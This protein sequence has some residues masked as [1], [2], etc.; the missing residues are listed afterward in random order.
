MFETEGKRLWALKLCKRRMTNETETKQQRFMNTILLHDVSKPTLFRATRFHTPRPSYFL[1]FLI[2]M[3]KR[4][5][6]KEVKNN[7]GF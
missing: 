7:G 2:D 1:R 5:A 6:E 3:Q 4:T